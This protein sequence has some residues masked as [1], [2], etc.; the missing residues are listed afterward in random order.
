M[1]DPRDG[2]P[3]DRLRRGLQRV[4]LE[5]GE[6]HRQ[7]ATGEETAAQGHVTA[8]D[9]QGIGKRTFGVRAIGLTGHAQTGAAQRLVAQLRI[10]AQTHQFV[11][12]QKVRLS[13]H[14]ERRP[15][16]PLWRQGDP[17]APDAHSRRCNDQQQKPPAKPHRQ[18]LKN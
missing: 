10:I 17:A 8:L 6:R 11:A 13:F 3:I 1:I 4:M 5:Q 14:I 12:G 15:G 9:T 2:L 7:A 16:I 18:P